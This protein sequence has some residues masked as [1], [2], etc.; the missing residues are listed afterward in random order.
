MHIWITNYLFAL[1][2]D[3]A[4]KMDTMEKRIM[5]KLTEIEEE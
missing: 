2:Q 1:Y 3:N 4:E 5:D